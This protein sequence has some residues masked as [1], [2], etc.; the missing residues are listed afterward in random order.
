MNTTPDSSS[1]RQQ[2]SADY[3]YP[4]IHSF[5][6]AER[7]QFFG[8]ERETKELYRLLV[9]NPVVVLFGKSGTGKTSLLQAGIAPLLNERRLQPVKL[10]LNDTSKPV[11]RQIWEQFNEADYLPLG[12]PDDLGLLEYCRRFDC[13]VAG[14]EMMPVLLLDQFEEIFTLYGDQPEQR[15]AFIEQLAELLNDTAPTAS[16]ET[17]GGAV[18]VVISIRSDFLYLLD[19]ISTR[20]PAI[21]RCR[22]ELSPLDEANARRAITAP[23]ALPGLFASQPFS[24]SPDALNTI[25]D[26][27]T[28][29]SDGGEKGREVEAF[30]LQQFCQRIERRLVD[31]NAPAGFDVTPAFFGG[32][33]GIE[34]IRDSF[35]A[36]VLDKFHPD[37]RRRVQQLVE[38]KL[39]SGERRIIAER[40]TLKNA[41][42]LTDSDLALLCRERLL[43]EEPRGSSYYYEISHDTLLAPVLKAKKRRLAEEEERK[44]AEELAAEEARIARE[45][46][47]A[48]RRRKRA[49][50]TSLVATI[51]VLAAV[52]AI[53]IAFH[54]SREAKQE[55]QK[56]QEA[57]ALADSKTRQ[58]E[59]SDSLAQV[60]TVAATAAEEAARL[61]KEIAELKSQE[62]KTATDQANIRKKEAEL[63]ALQAVIALLPQIRRDIL[64]L[65][66]HAAYTKVKNAASLQELK[67]S[68]AYESMEIA[69]FHHHSGKDELAREPY[70]LAADLLGKGA[71]KG[72]MDFGRLD[73]AR[74]QFLK[75]RYFGEMVVIQGGAFQMQG[76]QYGGDVEEYAAAVSDFHLSKYETT[77]WQYNLFCVDNGRSITQRI[78]SDG[79]S[80]EE[81]KYQPSWGW[82]G[83]NP[84]VYVS[85][86]DAV[87]YANWLS[88]KMGKKPAYVISTERDSLN[89]NE[90]DGYAWT[91]IPV[92]N[93]N[94]F[95]LPTELEWEFAARGGLRRDGFEYSGSDA[96]DSVA[97]YIEN[98]DIRTQV[99]GTKKVNGAGIF[100]MSGNVLEWC[101]DWYGDLPAENSVGAGKGSGRVIR[102]GSWGS[103]AVGCRVADRGIDGPGSRGDF[104]GFR[105]VFVP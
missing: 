17:R 62:A 75:N 7:N 16:G 92:P 55:A 25:L 100:D 33:Q 42:G 3:R 44:Q 32:Q 61:Q 31:E 26:G 83:N 68:L 84:V 59:Q 19:R 52:V 48:E 45:K 36:E 99:V 85:W 47:E 34:A 20:M 93:A 96:P 28:A 57:I 51:L 1:A 101:Y 18:R 46:A 41:L 78:S 89:E 77:V 74:A 39:I 8:R 70:D 63:A 65:D 24:Y 103:S 11:S 60:K 91:V 94:G 40:E 66:Y 30:L 79:S 56:A 21:L 2:A 71:L 23:A 29:Q 104:V 37:A 58:A 6:A 98:S 50:L 9:L 53:F 72:R 86:Y 81:E 12:T 102:G 22:Y 14:E 4:G 64:L 38:E 73:A 97:W 35:Y 105:L 69:W 5:T 54:Q 43:R 88:V 82:V 49:L 80:I 67:D 95:R 13:V 10:R 27:L 76:V 90:I 87:A 15:D